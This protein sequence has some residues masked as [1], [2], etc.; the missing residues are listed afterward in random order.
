[1]MLLPLDVY[2]VPGAST[3]VSVRSAVAS[4]VSGSSNFAVLSKLIN[5][6]R[7]PGS[8]AASALMSACIPANLGD[9]PS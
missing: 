5:E 4:V 3:W 9:A 1:M 2:A 8:S 7:A 6:N